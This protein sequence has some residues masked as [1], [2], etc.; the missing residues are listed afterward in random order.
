MHQCCALVDLTGGHERPTVCR[1]LSLT[2]RAQAFARRFCRRRQRSEHPGQ[3]PRSCAEPTHRVALCGGHVC[4][5]LPLASFRWRSDHVPLRRVGQGAL[6]GWSLCFWACAVT[7]VCQNRGGSL[8]IADVSCEVIRNTESNFRLGGL[9][10]VPRT[11]PCVQCL[12][13]CPVFNSAAFRQV[14]LMLGPS[15]WAP[16]S[17]RWPCEVCPSVRFGFETRLCA[18]C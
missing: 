11:L 5:A 16:S 13:S 15:A 1:E 12:S 17:C 9:G 6:G 3:V 4:F 7:I 18:R 14:G 8:E 2:A 10:L